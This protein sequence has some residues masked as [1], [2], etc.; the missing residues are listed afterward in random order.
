MD[1]KLRKKWF[2]AV[3]AG[4]ACAGLFV[5]LWLSRNASLHRE[6]K[7]EELFS[8][9]VSFFKKKKIEDGAL[10]LNV[11]FTSLPSC[12]KAPEAGYL[13]GVVK[14]FYTREIPQA[15]QIFRTVADRYPDTDAARKAQEKL[16][17]YSSDAFQWYKQ[18]VHE[19]NGDADAQTLTDTDDDSLLLTVFQ[20]YGQNIKQAVQHAGFLQEGAWISNETKKK[21]TFAFLKARLLKAGG[22][23]KSALSI[24]MK[25]SEQK[26]DVFLAQ[27]ASIHVA[28]IHFR[29][30]AYD[31]ALASL[32]HVTDVQLA[33]L[34]DY[35]RGEIYFAQKDVEKAAFF[36]DRSGALENLVLPFARAPSPYPEP[37]FFTGMEPAVRFLQSR[38]LNHLRVDV[39]KNAPSILATLAQEEKRALSP[40]EKN[41]FHRRFCLL[42]FLMAESE[43][44]GGNANAALQHYK[45]ILQKG[46]PPGDP[47]TIFPDTLFSAARLYVQFKKFLRAQ[48]LFSQ[49]EK[50]YP[51]DARLNDAKAYGYLC[52]EGTGKGEHV[53]FALLEDIIDKTGDANLTVSLY[54]LIV[55]KHQISHGDELPSSRELV[56]EEQAK[57]FRERLEKKL[58]SE[59][60]KT[61]YKAYDDV[62]LGDISYYSG[63]VQQAMNFF[64]S[65]I[66][67]K[68]AAEQRKGFETMK[69]F[70]PKPVTA[71]AY[72]KKCVQREKIM[73]LEKQIEKEDSAPLHTKLAEAYSEIGWVESAFSQ[74]RQ[75]ILLDA[76][77]YV[78][79]YKKDME[80]FLAG[81]MQLSDAVL[82]ENALLEED[83][84]LDAEDAAQL[85]WKVFYR[86]TLLKTGLSQ[87]FPSGKNELERILNQNGSLSGDVWASLLKEKTFYIPPTDSLRDFQRQVIDVLQL[88]VNEESTTV[89]SL[90]NLKFK[91][92]ELLAQLQE[93][94]G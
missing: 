7:C 42:L 29:N 21:N 9:A 69:T 70:S 49:F 32:A 72:L 28:D 17:I 43:E 37:A 86:E 41:G 14:E 77:S 93:A 26:D 89:G 52:M 66:A 3:F 48:T 47:D 2:A 30:K 85:L 58:L 31:D 22:R 74:W 59:K 83:A 19:K 80:E 50:N 65:S 11:L 67:K 8:R 20:Q 5:G 92:E 60:T 16:N 51:Q 56:E 63:N 75:A 35:G 6:Q 62:I 10:A 64:K 88:F 76:Q 1:K 25:L 12:G 39:L 23:Y 91:C 68:D 84:A 57:R 53:S 79:Q 55:K 18:N 34:A 44:E 4:A 24:F 94:E 90:R 40:A 87:K 73:S 46:A 54:Y 15:R 38:F 33:A 45:T 82:R 61:T 81:V 27:K 36:Y 71:A 78:P 13:S